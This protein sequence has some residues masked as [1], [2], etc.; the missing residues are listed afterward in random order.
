MGN[1]V[2]SLVQKLEALEHVLSVEKPTV[3]FLQETRLGRPGRIK[4][5][6]STKYSWYELHRTVMAEKGQKG[7]GIAIGVLN[8]VEPSWI[9]EGNDNTEAITVEIWIKNFPVRLICGYGPQEYD[10]KERKDSF[11]DYLTQEVQS[12]AAG[13]AGLI[14]Q[15]DGNLWPGKDI[16]RGDLKEQNQNGKMFHCFLNQNPSLSVVNALPQCEGTFT[17]VATTK[18]GTV[19]TILDFFVVCNKILP[20]VTKMKIDES[21]AISLTK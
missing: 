15:M 16:V 8:S 3:I 7:G 5:P 11:W 21:G 4:T 19:K 14:L 2:N 12:A 20:H 18:T 13:G 6:S 17:R 1:N 9:S 10:S